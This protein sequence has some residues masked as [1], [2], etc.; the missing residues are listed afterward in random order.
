MRKLPI[1]PAIKHMLQSIQHNWH[2]A[3]RIGLPW[4]ALI[5]ILNG[6]DLW[7]RPAGQTLPPNLKVSGIAYLQFAIGFVASSS[8][9]V[10][11]HR[12]ILLDEHP[13]KT[14]PFRVDQTVLKYLAKNF[15]IAILS[16]IPLLVMSEISLALPSLFLPVWLAATFLI[17][18]LMTRLSLSLVATAVVRQDFTLKNA[19]SVTQGNNLPIMG[20]I[21]LNGI[22]VG[23]ALIVFVILIAIINATLPSISGLATIVLQIPFLLAIIILNTT[24]L[25][26]LYGFFVENRDF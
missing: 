24:M 12:F 17:L 21:I 13:K 5:A 18:T 25:T 19:F 20:M 9:A 23:V 26:S 11:W 10:S 6:V 15:C 3:A 4:L 2:V 8:I 14:V 22:F 1:L 16:L 7:T